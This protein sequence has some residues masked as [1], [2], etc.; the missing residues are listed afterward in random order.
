MA[1]ETILDGKYR[2]TEMVGRGSFGKVWEAVRLSDGLEVAVKQLHNE[3]SNEQRLVARFDREARLARR[4][5]SDYVCRMLDASASAPNY[6]IVWELLRGET[7]KKLLRRCGLL[8]FGDALPLFRQTLQAL[9]DVHAAGIVHR[10]LKPSNVFVEWTSGTPQIKLIDFGLGKQSLNEPEGATNPITEE[11]DLVGSVGYMAP[12][13][14]TEA[15]HVD[16]RAD[17]YSFGVLVFYALAGRL[18]FPH[19]TAF[20]LFNAKLSERSP[21]LGETTGEDW[22]RVIEDWVAGLL[23]RHAGDRPASAAQALNAMNLV[24]RRLRGVLSTPPGVETSKTPETDAPEHGKVEPLPP[25]LTETL[26]ASMHFP[27]D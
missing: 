11:G 7:L 12:E 3:V 6:Y 4:I 23:S 25:E 1:D 15:R 22:P 27:Y 18:P 10:D 21:T 13:Q 16:E 24:D 20:E 26:T 14:L 2:L 19:K 8:S 17:I 5:D 9:I